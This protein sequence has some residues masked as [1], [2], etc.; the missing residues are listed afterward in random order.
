MTQLVRILLGISHGK[1][2]KSDND[3]FIYV[4][5]VVDQTLDNFVDLDKELEGAK[6]RK[7][8]S[9]IEVKFSI[10]AKSDLGR[11]TTTAL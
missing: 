10:G 7:G 11:T 2:L 3:F 6:A 1:I 4:Y 5:G 8:L 9:L